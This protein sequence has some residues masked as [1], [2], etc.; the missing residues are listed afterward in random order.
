MSRNGSTDDNLRREEAAC[1]SMSKRFGEEKKKSVSALHASNR[2]QYLA[3]ECEAAEKQSSREYPKN[4][5]DQ[6]SL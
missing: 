3:H 5:H 6:L 2:E 1:I 4:L